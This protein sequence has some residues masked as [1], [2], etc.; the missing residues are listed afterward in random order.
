M[1]RKALAVF[2]AAALWTLGCSDGPSPTQPNPILPTP[3]VL[4]TPTPASPDPSRAPV[5]T[6]AER[7]TLYYPSSRGW[8]IRG[9]NFFPD[10]VATF[11]SAGSVFLLIGEE[12][13]FQGELVG[14]TVPSGTP[15]GPYTPCVATVNGKGCGN[16]VITV[17]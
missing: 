15:A 13:T 6:S 5:V 4:P 10:P 7:T 12:S 1:I 3:N 2:A 17:D 8:I 14:V 9:S 11:E 16:F